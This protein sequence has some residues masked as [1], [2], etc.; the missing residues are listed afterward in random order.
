MFARTLAAATL[1]LSLAAPMTLVATPAH[2]VEAAVLQER[3]VYHIND[4]ANAT[5][6]LRN[7]KNHIQALSLIH[8]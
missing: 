1:A 4:S 6:A 7:I 2:A 5:A 3:V 8:I